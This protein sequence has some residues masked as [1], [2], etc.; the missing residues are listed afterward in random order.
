[1]QE[2]VMKPISQKEYAKMAQKASPSSPTGKNCLLA[3]ITGG[4]ICVLGQFLC[5]LYQQW[6]LSLP[7]AR[8]GV[9]ISLIFLSALLTGLGC[10]DNIARFAG[11]GTLVPITGFANAV[12]S[13]AMEFKSEGIITGM[14]VKTFTIA[15]PV[16]V[17]GIS[18]SV[19]YGI[20]FWLVTMMI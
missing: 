12:V 13:P 9:S 16:L 5:N 15:G 17:F 18:A 3:Y 20:F 10:F 4:G 6:G 8:A 14:G 1:M 19:L 11:A 7:M 2:A